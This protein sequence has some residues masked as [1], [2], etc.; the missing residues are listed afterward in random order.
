MGL[1]INKISACKVSLYYAI[2]IFLWMAI[3]VN[4]YTEQKRRCAQNTKKSKRRVRRRD[5]KEK[6]IH[7]GANH[8]IPLWKQTIAANRYF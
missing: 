4:Y 7:A 5:F 6:E 2:S 3:N 1:Y 8:R